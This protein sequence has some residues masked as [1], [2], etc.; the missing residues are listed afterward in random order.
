MVTTAGDFPWVAVTPDHVILCNSFES[1]Q[2]YGGSVVLIATPCVT[3]SEWRFGREQAKHAYSQSASHLPAVAPARPPASPV[4]IVAVLMLI[5][6]F[7][8]LVVALR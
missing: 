3:D 8:V 5:A 6:G 1:A 4:L 2:A 7:C